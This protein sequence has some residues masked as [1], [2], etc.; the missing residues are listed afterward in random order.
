[1]RI[2]SYF[3]ILLFFSFVGC[4]SDSSA[5]V[6]SSTDVKVADFA[7]S[8]Q[9]KEVANVDP[10][11]SKGDLEG[12]R[13][14][15]GK[16]PFSI[17]GKQ[18]F[19]NLPEVK[20]LLLEFMQLDDLKKIDYYTE[21][22]SV[23]KEVQGFLYMEIQ[24]GRQSPEGRSIYVAINPSTKE[25]HVI[26]VEENYEFI[27]MSNVNGRCRSTDFRSD[28]CRGNFRYEDLKNIRKQL[29]EIPN[30]NPK[31]VGFITEKYEKKCYAVIGR[32]AL[33]RELVASRIPIFYYDDEKREAVFNVDGKN[34][35][36]KQ[37]DLKGGVYTS[38]PDSFYLRFSDSEITV[39]MEVYE[40]DKENEVYKYGGK[41]EIKRGNQEDRKIEI[42]VYCN[43][44]I[45]ELDD[46][47]KKYQD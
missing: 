42:I 17:E 19:F 33:T 44:K 15:I 37:V 39:G 28:P 11:A 40:Y 20:K 23:I 41:M 46:E 16:Y 12:L 31:L 10:K 14:W 25:A 2:V 21:P 7:D 35:V 36:L 3:L 22:G 13:K 43:G 45:N 32:I 24:T 27:H 1:M 26:F 30:K 29:E 4:N 8:D 34:K 18:N 5:D 38:N 9:V 47:R 6:Q